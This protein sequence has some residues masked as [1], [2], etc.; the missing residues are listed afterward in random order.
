M[1]GS[2]KK[3][4]LPWLRRRV[5][6]RKQ[7]ELPILRGFELGTGNNF[8][9]GATCDQLV[10]SQFFIDPSFLRSSSRQVGSLGRKE[11]PSNRPALKLT[12][13]VLIG[14]QHENDQ[15]QGPAGPVVMGKRGRR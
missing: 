4:K 8:A 2:G 3:Q 13:D 1:R 9:R 7:S 15:P 10:L 14:S 11:S 12:G 5:P 6:L